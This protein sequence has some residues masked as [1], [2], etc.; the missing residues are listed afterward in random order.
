MEEEQILDP[1]DIYLRV[2]NVTASFVRQSKFILL[3]L[4]ALIAMN[5][6]AS[7][8]AQ[9]IRRLSSILSIVGTDDYDNQAMASNCLQYA[10]QLSQIADA[11]TEGHIDRVEPLVKEL[12]GVLGILPPY[13]AKTS[14]AP[15]CRGL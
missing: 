5:P 2:L 13:I 8:L 4:E 3:D 11:I 1:K 7:V 6:N 10:L 15:V 12:E 9:Q 14:E